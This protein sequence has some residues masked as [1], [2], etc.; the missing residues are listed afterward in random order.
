MKNKYFKISASTDDLSDIWK[1]RRRGQRDAERHKQRLRQAT[2]D[3]L[4]EII[5]QEDIISTDGS[6]KKIKIPVKY[7]EQWRFK[8][9]K[10]NKNHGVGHGG[11]GVD[12]GDVIHT[13]KEEGASGAGKEAGELIYEEFNLDEVIQMMMEDLD[14]PWLEDKPAQVE[15]ETD[16]ILYDDINKKGLMPNLDIRRTL[17]ENIKRN[18]VAGGKA[19]VGNF[20]QD[21]LRFKTYDV[22]KDYRSNAA[23]Y[24]IMDRSGSMTTDKKYVAK[25]FFF[26]M[27][28]FVKKKYKN[29][30]LVFIAHDT[31]AHFCNEHD[32]FNLSESGGTKCSSGFKAALDHINTNHPID[33]WN[34]YVFAFSDG[35]NQDEDNEACIAIVNN[36]LEHV[37]AIGYGEIVLSNTNSFYSNTAERELSTLQSIFDKN[38][39]SDK[40][41]SMSIN[42]KDDVYNCLKKFFGLKEEDKK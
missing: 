19:R 39:A 14:L 38:I 22:K 1:L 9:G 17:R 26:W 5:S 15:I 10:N 7:L 13:P 37:N 40:F 6:G 11:Q 34:N 16:T 32:F 31:D 33:L 3:N 2:K 42:K 28:Q 36:L 20:K 35:D 27:V 8:N 21:D 18:A 12:P 29:V 30:E 24:L 4:K 23:I 25:S 41:M